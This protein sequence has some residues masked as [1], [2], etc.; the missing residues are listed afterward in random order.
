MARAPGAQ[1][2]FRHG[3]AER[4]E[5]VM[6][7]SID[8]GCLDAFHDS[9]LELENKGNTVSVA[10]YCVCLEVRSLRKVARMRKLSSC[11]R[12][13]P[14]RLPPKGGVRPPTPVS[15]EGSLCTDSVWMAWVSFPNLNVNV[16]VTVNVEAPELLCG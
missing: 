9:P 10:D 7:K 14:V 5:K 12:W 6:E 3:T 4:D 2:S 15:I 11:Q 1:L 16:E 13:S 8:K